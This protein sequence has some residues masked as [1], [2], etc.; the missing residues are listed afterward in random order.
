MRAKKPLR[1][2]TEYFL[3]RVS[4]KNNW[5]GLY[6]CWNLK[7]GKQ[8]EWVTSFILKKWFYFSQAYNFLFW[9]TKIVHL[10][11]VFGRGFS[12]NLIKFRDVGGQT[13]QRWI[14]APLNG[15]GEKMHFMWKVSNAEFMYGIMYYNASWLLKHKH[16]RI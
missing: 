11:D 6:L 8:W 7:K 15:K 10:R 16:H 2:K 12:V 9:A 4:R 1:I 14:C 3:L 13:A 5:N